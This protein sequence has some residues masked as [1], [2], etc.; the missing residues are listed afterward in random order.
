LKILDA[1]GRGSMSNMLAAVQWVLSEG[2][3]QGIRVIN[4]SLAAY[5]DPSSQVCYV[6]DIMLPT[7][8]MTMCGFAPLHASQP[9]KLCV[10]A[11]FH[12]LLLLMLHHMNS[13]G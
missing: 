1:K 2:L 11:C 10:V 12:H 5:V 6:T 3:Q 8:Y 13:L 4:L 9:C 7:C